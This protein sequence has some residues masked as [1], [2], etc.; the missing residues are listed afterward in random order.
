MAFANGTT[1]GYLP[2][3]PGSSLWGTNVRKVIA[4]ADA[5]SDNTTVQNYGTNTGTQTRTVRP[6]ANSAGDA[7]ETLFGWGIQSTDMN[8][9]SGAQRMMAAGTHSFIAH[10]ETNSVLGANVTVNFWVYKIGSAAGGRV[11][12][13]VAVNSLATTF[14]AAA[15]GGSD[16]TVTASVPEIVFDAD[17]TIQW[18]LEFLSPG[19]AITGKTS[20]IYV[21]TH[22]A[23][24]QARVTFP[25]LKTVA[26]TTG[27][28]TGAGSASGVTGKVLGTEGSGSGSATAS[29]SMGSTGGMVGASAG[30]GTA[31]AVGASIGG[32]TGSSVGA[33]AAAGSLGAVGSMTGSSSGS[34]DAAASMSSVGSMTGSAAGL[35]TVAGSVSSVAGTTGTA[36]GEGAAEGLVSSVAGTVGSAAGSAFIAGLMSKVLGTVGTVNVSE[37]GGTT[38]V[39]RKKVVVYD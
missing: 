18:S 23:G 19:V 8:S 27:S 33:G 28:S 2:I 32:M 3:A 24:T 14:G 38:I 36:T 30:N 11:P 37:G 29:G 4:S 15:T 7:D 21:G 9:V 31:S 13:Q 25:A 5:T 22:S 34:S 16:L 12:T 10:V 39:R 26:P 35:G 6:M 1:T 17:E 20:T